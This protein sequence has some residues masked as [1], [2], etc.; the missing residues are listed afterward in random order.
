[1]MTD[2]KIIICQ[3]CDNIPDQTHIWWQP[4]QQLWHCLYTHQISESVCWVGNGPNFE[5]PFSWFFEAILFEVRPSLE[6]NH[7]FINTQILPWLVKFCKCRIE[8]V[9]Q[10]TN[11]VQWVIICSIPCRSLG[12][13]CQVKEPVQSHKPMP[14]HD[15]WNPGI[16]DTWLYDYW[17]TSSHTAVVV[18]C[19]LLWC[20][21]AKAC[22]SRGF[23]GVHLVLAGFPAI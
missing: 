22:I 6:Q 18:S 10:R 20:W 7:R 17:S 14:C 2:I 12:T 16:I 4:G 3:V 8:L 15:P 5:S 11:F 9:Y 21:Y 1:M 23:V 19:I 13:V